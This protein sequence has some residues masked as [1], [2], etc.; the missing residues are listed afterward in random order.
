MNSR[1]PVP[2]EMENCALNPLVGDYKKVFEAS[3]TQ[4][5]QAIRKAVQRAVK[6]GDIRKE[7]YPGDLLRV[8]DGVA[9]VVCSPD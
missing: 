8:L 9:N 2:R 3:Y 7:L 4:V 6:R 1:V 5:H